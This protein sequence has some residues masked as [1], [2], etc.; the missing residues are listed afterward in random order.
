MADRKILHR[1]DLALLALLAVTYG[2]SFLPFGIFTFVLNLAIAGV[3]ASLVVWFFMNLRLSSGIV[4]LFAG[5]A[6]LWVL[7]LFALGFN[8]WLT[9]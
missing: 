8:D 9:R 4:R 6:L 2:V 5:S 3:Q 7:V 1:V